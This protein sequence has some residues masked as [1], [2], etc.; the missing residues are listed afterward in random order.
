METD[1]YTAKMSK[2]SIMVEQINQ[3]DQYFCNIGL[4]QKGKLISFLNF[5]IL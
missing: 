2:K 3:L 1:S 4:G 5:Q